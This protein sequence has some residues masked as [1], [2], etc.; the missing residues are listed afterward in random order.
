MACSASH[1]CFL[2]Q[3]SSL[4]SL[5]YANPQ[6]LPWAC[7]SI[8]YP[9]QSYC[10]DFLYSMAAQT[11]DELDNMFDDDPSLS[12]SLEDFDETQ[13]RSPLF[14]LHSQHSGFRSEASEADASSNGEPF[15]PPA[16]TRARES[17]GGSGWYSHQPYGRTRFGPSLSPSASR[18]TSPQYEDA[19]E[20]D[21]EI[22]IAANI[23]LPPGTDSPLK[24]RSPSP[25]PYRETEPEFAQSTREDAGLPQDTSNNCS[26][27]STV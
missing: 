1:F 13:N 22:T 3:T 20:E 16:W 23:P 2:P 4:G 19:K 7:P 6:Y 14:G 24:G 11:S 9:A 15:S 18:E 12:A 21:P 25:D 17:V 26:S 27:R 5:R 10:V 8:S